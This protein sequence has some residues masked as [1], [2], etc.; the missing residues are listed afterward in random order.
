V[1]GDFYDVF[2]SE[3]GT[4]TAIIGDVSGKGPAAAS[5]TGLARHTLYATAMTEKRPM[6]S[7]ARLNEVMLR[8]L[9]EPAFCTVVYSRVC[10][11][12]DSTLVTLA[13]G[14]HPH[15]L[16]LRADGTVERVELTGT[17]VG[18]VE[19]ARFDERD[20][21]LAPGDLLLLYTDGAVELRRSDLEFGERELAQALREHAGRPA[22][23][24]VQAVADRIEE[25]RDGSARDDVALLALRMTPD[26]VS[27]EP[28]PS[29][30]AGARARPRG[31]A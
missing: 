2:A 18:I 29:R 12:P 28:A 25:A 9:R 21:R 30:R 16:I 10:P 27:R 7:L 31:T 8:R 22:E 1:G 24:V 19:D 15:P 23:E 26:P 20:V 13:G 6:Q 11:G 4:W 14:G 17:L 3:E 5:L